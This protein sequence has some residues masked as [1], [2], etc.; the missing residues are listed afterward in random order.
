MRKSSQ[1]QVQVQVQVLV[2]VLV[3]VLVCRLRFEMR[4]GVV[5]P[6][7]PKQCRRLRHLTWCGQLPCVVRLLKRQPGIG[8]GST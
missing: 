5:A 7:H 2:L 3:L 6:S 1:V 8:D 4:A